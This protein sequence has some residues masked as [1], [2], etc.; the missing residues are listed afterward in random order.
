LPEYSLDLGAFNAPVMLHL[1]KLP[2]YSEE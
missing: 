1:I 2:G